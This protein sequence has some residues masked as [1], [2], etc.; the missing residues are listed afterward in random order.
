MDREVGR[1]LRT[2]PTWLESAYPI[3]LESI[4]ERAAHVTV[5]DRYADAANGE[6]TDIGHAKRVPRTVDDCSLQRL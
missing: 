1:L 5:Q 4:D 2:L 3:I 6:E